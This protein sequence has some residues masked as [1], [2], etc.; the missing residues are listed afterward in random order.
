MYAKFII[1]VSDRMVVAGEKSFDQQFLIAK[2]TIAGKPIICGT[3]ML[4]CWLYKHNPSEDSR[5]ADRHA[6]CAFEAFTPID[7]KQMAEKVPELECQTQ[8][9]L[10]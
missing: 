2:C 7:G 8:L 4:G 5:I 9:G 10:N 1:A 3:Q 6:Q